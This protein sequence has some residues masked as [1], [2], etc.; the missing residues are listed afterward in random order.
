MSHTAT[1]VWGDH[2]LM[3][4]APMDEL[5]EEFV[6]IIALLQ[7]AE[8]SELPKLLQALFRTLRARRKPIS[9]RRTPIASRR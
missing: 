2:L 9:L 8:D 4:H 1:L 7:T 6:E 3:G 5:H